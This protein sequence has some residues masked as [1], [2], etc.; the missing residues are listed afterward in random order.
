VREA[1]KA[2]T[3]RFTAKELIAKRTHLRD[4]IATPLRD[5]CT[6]PAGLSTRFMRGG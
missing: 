5:Q 2:V 3:A 1:V 4:R 6:P